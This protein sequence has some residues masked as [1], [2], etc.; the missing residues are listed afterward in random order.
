MLTHYVKVVIDKKAPIYLEKSKY[1]TRGAITFL[2]GY[3]VNKSG[4]AD[5]AV[6]HLI[7][8]GENGPKVYIQAMN[9]TYCELEYADPVS[10]RWAPG[11]SARKARLH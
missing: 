3:Q 7:Q 6:L 5:K 11:V 4:D 10:G 2:S 9:P 8:I 1:I